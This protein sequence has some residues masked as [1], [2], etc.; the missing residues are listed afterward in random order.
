MWSKLFR[1]SGF[2]LGLLLTLVFVLL[3][4]GVLISTGHATDFLKDL[5]N[6]WSDAKFVLRGGPTTPEERKKFQDS[7][8]VVIVAIDEKSVRMDDLGIWPWPRSQIA[9]LVH[10]LTRCQAKVVGF[11]VVFS[12]S[13]SSRIAPVVQSIK[14]RYGKVSARDEGFEKDLDE[15][16]EQVQ[17]DKKLAAE[18]EK[19]PGVVLGYFFFANPD[20]VERLSQAEIKEGK[21]RIGFGTIGFVTQYPGDDISKAFPRALGV[22][23]NLPLLTETAELYGFFNQIPD[24]DGLYRTVPLVFLMDDKPYPALSLQCLAA[25]YGQPVSLLVHTQTQQEHIEGEI[26]LFLGPIGLPTPQHKRVPVEDRGLFRVNYY[27]RGKTFQHVSA[28][29]IIHGDPEACAAVRDKVVLV[30]ATTMGIFDLRSTAFEPNFPGVEIHAS[31][32]ENT[33]TGAYLRRN[34]RVFTAFEALFLIGV[35]VFFSWLLNRFRLTLGLVVTL[36]TLL[37]VLVG[38]YFLLFQRGLLAYVVLP[39]IHLVVLFLGIAVYRYATEEREKGKIRQ[40]FQFYLSKDVIASVLEDPSKLKLG[41]E[42]RELTVLFSDIRGF[43]TISERLDPEA[44]SNLL[45][46]YLTPMTDL[47]FR[48]QG[49]LDKYMG[50]AVMAFFGAPM[51]FAEHPQAACRTALDMMEELH[52]L[53]ETWKARGLPLL[54]IGIGL[55]TG[56]MSVGNMGSANRFDYTVMGDNVN[57][58]SRLEGLNKQ[59]GSHIIISEFTEAAVRAE[60]TCRELDSVQVKGKNEPV[61]IYELVHRGPRN[62]PQDDWIDEYLEALAV[63]RAQRWDEAIERFGRLSTDPTAQM[64]VERCRK[65]KEHPPEPGWNGVYKMTSK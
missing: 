51:P 47:V 26:G 20:E 10:E 56:L 37:G 17:G 64:Y 33:I 57:L 32:I 7:A 8:H 61:R 41:G 52:K 34:A 38:D 44:L 45:N 43:T 13:D 4:I 58:G 22:R 24:Q 42:R 18:L 11:D 35:G 55:N 59:Y 12:E 39:E 21:E 36:F 14:D 3:K 63:Y 30:G 54:D 6:L 29:D 5:E 50:D 46:E 27:G 31:V 19:A 25:Y 28:G 1:P 9:T 62:P 65:M 40:A 23:A 53:Q 15:I 48:H 2:K 49:T 16:L 60:F